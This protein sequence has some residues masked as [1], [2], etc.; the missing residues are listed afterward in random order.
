MVNI[1]HPGFGVL[2]FIAIIVLI[3]IVIDACIQSSKHR[4]K[5]EEPDFDDIKY[6]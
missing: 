2:G 5:P 3:I 4:H 6:P 1:I